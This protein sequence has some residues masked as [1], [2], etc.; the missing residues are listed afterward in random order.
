MTLLVLLGTQVC[1][2]CNRNDDE[3]TNVTSPGPS[4]GDGDSDGTG[5][6]TSAGGATGAPDLPTPDLTA[7]AAEPGDAPFEAICAFYGVKRAAC[8]DEGHETSEAAELACREVIYRATLADGEACHD[9]YA[10]LYYCKTAGA[11]DDLDRPSCPKQSDAV[12]MACP[13]H[14]TL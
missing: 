11:C 8:D 13:H 1:A 7:T 6:S 9:A 14:P 5:T 4:T 10:D 2:G 12:A 3:S